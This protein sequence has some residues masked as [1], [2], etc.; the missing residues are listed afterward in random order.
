M[1]KQPI[2]TR[3]QIVLGLIMGL[4][5]GICGSFFTKYVWPRDSDQIGKTL[6]AEVG[7]G[8]VVG[9]TVGLVAR[10]VWPKYKRPKKNAAQ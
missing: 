9:L 8:I 2:A 1:E 7:V 10:Y 3:R 5:I 4:I 6:I